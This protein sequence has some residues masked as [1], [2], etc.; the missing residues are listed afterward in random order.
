MSCAY[1]VDKETAAE[2]DEPVFGLAATDEMCQS[3][4][5]VYPRPALAAAG[6]GS[7]GSV[8]DPPSLTFCVP[9]ANP[10][11]RLGT[12]CGAFDSAGDDPSGSTLAID[13]TTRTDTGGL[14]FSLRRAP[15]CRATSG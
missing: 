2:G 15:M 12:S 5:L 3:Y 1:G 14:A 11:G 7:G 10:D 9:K 4:L 13:S 8:G 6:G